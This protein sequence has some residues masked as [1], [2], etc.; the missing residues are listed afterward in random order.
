M[1]RLR[2]PTLAAGRRLVATLL[3]AGAAACGGD[4]SGPQS[5]T[6]PDSGA[7]AGKGGD[8][9]A[10]APSG[11]QDLVKRGERI[12]NVNC[13][14]CHNR[15]PS[16]GGGLGPAVAGSSYELLEA[17]VLR[18]EYPPGYTPKQETGLMVPLPHLEPEID[19]LAAYLG[20]I[21]E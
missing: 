1:G 20:S 6:S 3:V 13:I 17:R 15:D 7:Q 9:A 14:A 8:S 2:I 18:A 4:D 19:A 21:P 11:E 10:M 12:Y 5:A 16:Q